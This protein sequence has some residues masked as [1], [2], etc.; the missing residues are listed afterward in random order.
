MRPPLIA[1]AELMPGSDEM[2]PVMISDFNGFP[3]RIL[4]T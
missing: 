4:G 2:D 3:A 1:P